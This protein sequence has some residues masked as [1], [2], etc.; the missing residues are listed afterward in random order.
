MLQCFTSVSLCV[1]HLFVFV[2]CFV[3][4][5]KRAEEDRKSRAD[6]EKQ[7]AQKKAEEEKAKKAQSAAPAQA[8]TTD[9]QPIST[10]YTYEVRNVMKYACGERIIRGFDWVCCL[11]CV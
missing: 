1:L 3:K 6:Q 10:L 9:F 4:D 11:L 2:W 7:E 8:Q 5:R